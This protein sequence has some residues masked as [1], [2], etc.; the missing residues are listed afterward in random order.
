LFS[1]KYAVKTVS[2]RKKRNTLTIIGIALGV[3]M[4]A[5]AQIATDTLINSFNQLIFEDLGK[6]DIIIKPV[7]ENT[8]F[9]ETVY[10]MLANNENIT[11]LVQNGKEGLSPR[12]EIPAFVIYQAKGQIETDALVIGINN[13]LD[14]HFGPLINRTSGEEI[15]VTPTNLNLG[16]VVIGAHLADT[17]R[18]DI[19]ENNTIIVGFIDSLKRTLNLPLTVKYIAKTE[20]KATFNGGDVIFFPLSHARL[21]YSA[22]PQA[23]NRIIVDTKNTEKNSEK[24]VNTIKN[25]LGEEV[26]KFDLIPIRDDLTEDISEG[27]SDFETILYFFG[28]FV[29]LSG[30]ILIV[31]IGL[32]NVEERKRTI[33]VLRA[34]G[35]EKKQIIS[36]FMFESIIL[37]IIAAFIGAAFGIIIGYFLTWYLAYLFRSGFEELENFKVHLLISPRIIWSSIFMGL[38][39]AIIASIYPAIK[40]SRVDVVETLKGFEKPQKKKA[41]KKTAI[42]GF[43]LTLTGLS[44]LSI[45]R[46]GIPLLT[47]SVLTFV[48]IGLIASKYI[49]KKIAYDFIAISLILISTF[50]LLEQLEDASNIFLIITT[51]TLIGAG[52]LLIGINLNILTDGINK[53]FMRSKRLRSIGLMATKYVSGQKTRSAL[54]FSIFAIIL[55]M[56]IGLAIFG[57]S[58]SHG[59]DKYAEEVSAGSDIYASSIIPITNT[60]VIAMQNI[61]TDD[62]KGEIIHIEPFA[63]TQFG[64]DNSVLYTSNN[65]IKENTYETAIY[66]VSSNLTKFTFSEQ[67]WRKIDNE[68]LKLYGVENPWQL[69]TINAKDSEGRPYMVLN[70]WIQFDGEGTVGD[71]IW[72]KLENGTLKEFIVVAEHQGLP[73]AIPFAVFISSKQPVLATANQVRNNMSSAFLIQTNAKQLNS[74]I[75][76]DLAEEIE[77]YGNKENPQRFFYGIEAITTWEIYEIILQFFSRFIIFINSFIFI[78]FFIGIL[79]LLIV[80]LRSVS[81]RRREIGMMRS[82]GFQQKQVVRAVLLEILIVSMLG[83]TIG[84]INGIIFTY[85]VFTVYIEEFQYTIPWLDVLVYVALT[86]LFSF[87]AA[88]YPGKKVAKIHPSEALR[89]VG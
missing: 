48:G 53:I 57:G 2:K 88:W 86:L 62:G 13:T 21:G 26:E 6:I 11:K 7:A 78:G 67:N 72:L 38:F 3:A 59:F 52:I 25:A 29:V 68:V 14:Q 17:L 76:F 28:S 20:G 45:Q 71:S 43:I 51:F 84:L 12:I 63:A 89:Y 27:F 73:L 40:A 64:E 41:G 82:I 46:S 58:L 65:P 75:N 66:S 80:A 79:G 16:E 22:E 18:I 15:S 55:S 33:G 39:I 32:M 44:L 85:A 34:I 74:K 4:V 69:L 70:H 9:D 35:M 54:T 81:E 36:H 77:E 10:H 47:A 42:F 87:L 24:T 83:L 30:I 50:L 60:T 23:I 19:K 8:T 1:A 61:K 56:S 49:P 31:N 5:S 37:G